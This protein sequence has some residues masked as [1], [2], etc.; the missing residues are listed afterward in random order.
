MRH[1]G[2]ESSSRKLVWVEEHGVAGWGCSECAWVFN[3][4]DQLTGESVDEMRRNFQM[5]LSEEFA[6][7]TCAQRTAARNVGPSRAEPCV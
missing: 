4:P 6:S 5:Q 3:L 7:H 1:T 2:P